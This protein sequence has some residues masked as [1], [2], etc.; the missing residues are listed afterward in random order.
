MTRLLPALLVALL[1]AGTADRATSQG[2]TPSAAEIFARSLKAIHA[3]DSYQGRLVMR[4]LIGDELE[5]SKIHFKF[6]RPFKVYM[7]YITPSEGQEVLFVRGQNDNEILAHKGSFPDITVS[8]DPYGRMA[9]KGSHQPILTFGLQKQIEIMGHIYRKAVA[10]GE[11][12]YTVKDAGVFMGE[13]VWEIDARLPSTGT[14]VKVLENEDL[15]KLATRVGQTMYVI[16]HY[17]G[18]RSPDSINEGDEIFVPDHYGSR[19]RYLIAKKS[20]MPL[21]ETSWDHAGRLYESYEYPEIILDAGLT[22]TDFDRDNPAYG[23]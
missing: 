3:V 1:I 6:K 14:T 18:I 17:N 10:T 9:M 2:G 4:E 5:T 21:Q 8:L 13:P 20:L 19:V 16:L 12:T 15:W 23:F 11:V 22:D 7:K